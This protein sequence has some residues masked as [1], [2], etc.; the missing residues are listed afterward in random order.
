M[1]Y[2][3]VVLGWFVGYGFTWVFICVVLLI[4]VWVGLVWCRLLF[5]CRWVVGCILF[6]VVG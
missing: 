3:S 5:C 2:C 6:V 1:L 4:V